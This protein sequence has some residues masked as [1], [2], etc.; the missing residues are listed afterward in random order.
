M[1]RTARLN[2]STLVIYKDIYVYMKRINT[3]AHKYMYGLLTN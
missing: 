1:G 3:T 2:G